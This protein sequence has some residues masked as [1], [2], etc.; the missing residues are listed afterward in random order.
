MKLVSLLL[1]LFFVT[2]AFAT[3]Q[4]QLVCN[5]YY[6]NSSGLQLSKWNQMPIQ[7]GSPVGYALDF[8][9]ARSTV[10][11][12]AGFNVPPFTRASVVIT[13]RDK[14]SGREFLGQRGSEYR[15]EL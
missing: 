12:F 14:V 2:S 9:D 15:G 6:E 11:I 13:Y 5:Q 8:Q 7:W 4:G 10:S 1:P 3:G